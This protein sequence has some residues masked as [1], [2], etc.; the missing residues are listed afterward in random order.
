MSGLDEIDDI[1]PLGTPRP[2][3]HVGSAVLPEV[4]EDEKAPGRVGTVK[5]TVHGQQQT[6]DMSVSPAKAELTWPMLPPPTMP[7]LPSPFFPMPA[8]YFGYANPFAMSM[9]PA[10]FVPAPGYAPGADG[11]VGGIGVANPTKQQVPLLPFMPCVSSLPPVA[12][13]TV[14]HQPPVARRD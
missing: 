14:P 4:N 5:P 10:Y 2:L 11:A 9:P 13:S 7:C 8:A 3:T 6:H 1:S 12:G